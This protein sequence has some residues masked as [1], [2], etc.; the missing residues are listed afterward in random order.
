V[1]PEHGFERR[2]GQGHIG[3]DQTQLAHRMQLPHQ[4]SV[5][6]LKMPFGLGESSPLLKLDYSSHGRLRV[7]RPI[8]YSINL[9]MT[10]AMIGH[11]HLRKTR[12]L[13]KGS[14]YPKNFS[15]AGLEEEAWKE[16]A[17]R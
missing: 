16:L 4:T 3:T 12:N 11:P 7:W 10:G 1:G 8:P 9:L 2:L 13:R 15:Q 17:E 14:T 5:T 6:D